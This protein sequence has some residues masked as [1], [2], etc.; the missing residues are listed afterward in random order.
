MTGNAQRATVRKASGKINPL[1]QA[2]AILGRLGGSKTSSKKAKASRLNG[3][4]GG[5]RNASTEARAKGEHETEE[6]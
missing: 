6:K 2:A 3:R 5:R 4:K 1:S